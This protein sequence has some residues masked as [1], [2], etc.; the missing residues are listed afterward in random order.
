MTTLYN[1]PY[2]EVQK[3]LDGMRENPNTAALL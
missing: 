3:R 2:Q 1:N